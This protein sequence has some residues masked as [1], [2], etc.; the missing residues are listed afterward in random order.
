MYKTDL[1]EMY[2][3]VLDKL[4]QVKRLP[5]VYQE[6]QYYITEQ[7]DF[8]YWIPPNWIDDGRDHRFYGDSFMIFS[9]MVL[10]KKEKIML[11]DIKEK[12]LTIQLDLIKNLKQIT[13]SYL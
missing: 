2:V 12:E 13:V 1:K 7:N 11:L 8:F 9:S 4:Y 10:A 3:L 6:L 5:C